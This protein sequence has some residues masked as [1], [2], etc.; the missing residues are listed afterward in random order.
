VSVPP[1]GGSTGRQ[2]V[3]N[4]CI[5]DFR[6]LYMGIRELRHQQGLCRCG[7]ERVP[8]KKSCESCLRQATKAAMRRYRNGGRQ[9]QLQRR[10]D[11]TSWWWEYRATL[12]CQQCG[13]SHPAALDFH[14]RDPKQ[15]LFSVSVAAT[16]AGQ[17]RESILAEIAKCDVLCANCHRIL[18]WQDRGKH[19]KK[20]VGLPE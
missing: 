6:R 15:K 17:S 9:R 2:P 13:F 8:G 12:R 4:S 11:S 1:Y 20:V 5:I 18:H 10:R 14:H 16:T 7:A 19:G 3:M